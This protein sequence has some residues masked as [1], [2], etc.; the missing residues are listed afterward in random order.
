MLFLVGHEVWVYGGHESWRTILQCTVPFH[1][2]CNDEN[3]PVNVL[4]GQNAETFV[5]DERALIPRCPFYNVTPIP[6]KP[7]TRICL[8]VLSFLIQDLY[9]GREVT[10]Y[11]RTFLKILIKS[12]YS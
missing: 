5:V 4:T 3:S 12:F 11:Q 8:S 1:I 9:I 2:A 7:W 6:T 10:C